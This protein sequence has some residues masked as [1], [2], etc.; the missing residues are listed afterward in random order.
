M[1]NLLA[2]L[3]LSLVIFLGLGWYLG[4][5][6]IHSSPS[7]DGHRQIQIDLNTPKIKQDLNSGREKLRDWLDFDDPTENTNA[8]P[9]S[10]TSFRKD[11][12]GSYIFPGDKTPPSGAPQLPMPK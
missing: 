4:W 12:D 1:R 3:G 8:G 7:A 2:L 10:S 11:A 6:K 5:Y 9:G